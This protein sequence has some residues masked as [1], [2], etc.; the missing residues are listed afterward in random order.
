MGHPRRFYRPDSL[1]LLTNR[2]AEGLAFVPNAY[3]CALLGGVFAEASRRYPKIHLSLYF[4]LQNHY[5]L[6]VHTSG[7][8][9]ELRSFLEYID[10]EIAKL[11]V[12]LLGKRNVKVWAQ[13][14]HVALIA[15]AEDALEKMAYALL[16]PVAA[17]FCDRAIDWR[18]FSSAKFLYDQSPEFYKRVYPR[19]VERLPNGC[20]GRKLRRTL[21]EEIE[22]LPQDAQPLIATPFS[23]KRCFIET[24]DSSDAELLQRL[25]AKVAFEESRYRKARKTPLPTAE[26][27]ASQNAHKRYKPKKFG[28]RV[29]CICCNK[30]LRELLLKEY[31]EF[32]E[33]C[34]ICWL[35]SR[36][37]C[38]D[39]DFPPGAFRP[40]RVPNA[41][42]YQPFHYS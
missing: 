14:A 12:R 37:G 15:T 34:K 23:W 18:G 27:L 36:N 17:N 1:Y 25:E 19:Q 40:P 9:A 28:R 30:E 8:P 5:H 42:A 11:V 26:Q 32:C 4:F 3:I 16:N 39:V 41:T 38:L 29:Y 21:L 10:G 35:E 22:A 6:L 24:K 13:R 7:D 20:F 31:R 2:L 33:Q